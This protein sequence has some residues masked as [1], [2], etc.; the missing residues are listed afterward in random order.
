[1]ETGVNC[2]TQAFAAQPFALLKNCWAIYARKSFM[3]F[4]IFIALRIILRLTLK[5]ETFSSFAKL[6]I[7]YQVEMWRQVPSEKTF[8]F[9]ETKRDLLGLKQFYTMIELYNTPRILNNWM[10]CKF[11]KLKLIY[12]CF[13][14]SSYAFWAQP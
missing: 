7:V 9:F 12:T 8:K 5:K 2:N 11:F 13:L 3:K 6:L 14:S 4:W 10:F 1:M